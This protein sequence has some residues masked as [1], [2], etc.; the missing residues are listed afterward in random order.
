MPP[1]GRLYSLTHEQLAD[2]D[3]MGSKSSSKLIHALDKSRTTTLDRFIYA[4]GIR[5]VGETTA[6]TL[7]K[8]FKSFELIQQATADELE[9][10]SDV[11]PIIAKNI[12]SF[13]QQ[14]HNM[15]IIQRLFA[16][17]I[18]WDSNHDEKNQIFDGLSF[19][20]TGS[21]QKM[22]R[23]DAKQKLYSLGAKVSGSVSK[24]TNYV[25]YGDNPGSKYGKALKLG[26]ETIT[27]ESFLQM[28]REGK[29]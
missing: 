13:F 19:V 9:T 20:L 27:E 6:R 15:E 17:G 3:R 11:G 23:E 8:H 16:A 28:I 12:H 24:K 4:L 18:H 22:T 2:L 26:V 1:I 7:A 5:D 21:L 10:I 14:A 25:V 29:N